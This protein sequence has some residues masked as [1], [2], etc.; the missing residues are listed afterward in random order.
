MLRG[1]RETVAGGTIR[2]GTDLTRRR[3]SLALA[4]PAAIPA[5]I[6]PE[7]LAPA[8]ATKRRAA[9]FLSLPGVH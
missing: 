6:L 4:S 1:A 7:V 2:S 8:L 9:G 5:S 3:S